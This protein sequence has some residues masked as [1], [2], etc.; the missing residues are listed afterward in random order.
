MVVTEEE[1]NKCESSHPTFF[2]NNG[3]TEVRLD[4]PGPF[5]FISGVTGH[6]QGGQRMVIKVI[7]KDTPPSAPPSGAAL[8][9]FG[10]AG[11]IA[12]F[13][14]LLLHVFVMHSI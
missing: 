12:V 2:S 7:S 1:Y 13:M 10:S 3:N 14:V 11:A 9:G 6:C 5:Y 4:R 8:T